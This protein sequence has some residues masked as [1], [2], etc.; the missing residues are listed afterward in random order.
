MAILVRNKGL[1]R[2]RSRGHARSAEGLKWQA[3]YAAAHAL[4]ECDKLGGRRA[5]IGGAVGHGGAHGKQ[6]GAPLGSAGPASCA[7]ETRSC[8]SSGGASARME[9]AAAACESEQRHVV[10][11]VGTKS[12]PSQTRSASH[13]VILVRDMENAKG[14][15]RATSARPVALAMAPSASPQSR[16]PRH[17]SACESDSNK[18]T[19]FGGAFPPFPPPAVRPQA[20]LNSSSRRGRVTAQ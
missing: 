16:M 11:L 15:G 8:L 14:A 7:I 18:N 4:A 19:G 2:L 13:A 10:I 6:R 12:G 1:S 17:I 9:A 20:A 3:W 5:I